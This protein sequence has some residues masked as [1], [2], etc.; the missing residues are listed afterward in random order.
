MTR[1]ERQSWSPDHPVSRFTLALSTSWSSNHEVS[2]HHVELLI[3]LFV[4]FEFKFDLCCLEDDHVTA[5]LLAGTAPPPVL[6]DAASST[7]LAD[8]AHPPVLADAAAA[9]LLADAA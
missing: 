3:W 5:A 2:L 6:A 1:L 8:A 4:P 7:L 9:A